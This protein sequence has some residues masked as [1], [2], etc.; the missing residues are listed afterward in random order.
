[1]QAG[2]ERLHSKYDPV[3]QLARAE[4]G[5]LQAPSCRPEWDPVQGLLKLGHAL[6]DQRLAGEDASWGTAG[7]QA[8]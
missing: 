6:A 5:K 7:A 1:M 2:K 8:A 4:P 3:W